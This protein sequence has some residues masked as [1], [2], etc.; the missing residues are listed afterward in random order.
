[1][2]SWWTWTELRDVPLLAGGKG[3]TAAL[4][5][6]VEPPRVP[7]PKCGHYARAGEPCGVCRIL[8]EEGES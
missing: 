5:D 6:L 1:M 8:D 2:T 7:C 4:L 3:K